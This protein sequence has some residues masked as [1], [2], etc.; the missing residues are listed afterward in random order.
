MPPQAQPGT[1][2]YTLGLTLETTI[3]RDWGLYVLGGNYTA[4]WAKAAPCGSSSDPLTRFHQCQESTPSAWTWNPADLRHNQDD[5][6]HGAPG[7][8]ATQSDVLSLYGH[9]GYKEE[10]ATQS[11]G[12][13][14]SVP[15]APTY[16]WDKGPSGPAG[17]VHRNRDVTL[18]LSY[19]VELNL[20]PRNYPIFLAV[21]VPIV[22]NPVLDGDFPHEPPNYVF[23]AGIKGTFL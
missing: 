18:K 8:G 10:M 13:T 2:H 6:Y 19:G 11:A 1:G 23:T 12:V 7:T 15:M 22:L 3:D 21:G 16:Y 20:N 5:D 17:T 14:L 4:A 9:V